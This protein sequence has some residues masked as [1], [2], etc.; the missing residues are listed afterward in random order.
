[1]RRAG[2]IFEQ[3]SYRG[4]GVRTI[5]G[6]SLAMI[7]CTAISALAAFCIIANFGAVTAQIAIFTVNL[8]STGFPILAAVIVVVYF[9]ARLKW[10][11][12]RNFWGW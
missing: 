10:K 12:R 4:T 7:I 9:I 6:V 5:S 8:L 2:D 3:E 11:L 1:M